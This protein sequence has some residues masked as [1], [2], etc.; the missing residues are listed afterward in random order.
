MMTTFLFRAQNENSGEQDEQKAHSL[1][2]GLRQQMEQMAHLR[3]CERI[4]QKDPADRRPGDVDSL[5]R[6]TKDINFIK[7]LDHGVRRDL[8]YLM[9]A[10]VK[11]VNHQLTLTEKTAAMLVLMRGEVDI[12]TNKPP[13]EVLARWNKEQRKPRVSNARRSSTSKSQSRQSLRSSVHEEAEEQQ[14]AKKRESEK[15]K[16]YEALFNEIDADGNQSLDCDE[17]VYAFTKIGSTISR[18]EVEQMVQDVN[19]DGSW[20]LDFNEFCKV[21]DLQFGGETM[22]W[23]EIRPGVWSKTFSAGEDFGDHLLTGD[24]P[25]NFFCRLFFR[26]ESSCL[27]VYR[28]SYQT[29]LEG[30]FDEKLKHGISLLHSTG[31]FFPVK[32]SPARL[33]SLASHASYSAIEKGALRKKSFFLE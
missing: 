17:L 10:E 15:R 5:N 26:D 19:E 29:V 9:T 32:Q 18:V 31:I 16:A 2:E 28:H 6:Q 21:L 3:R 11:E 20:E 12:T 30:G 14:R 23:E 24:V 33:R 13:N 25:K 22:P 1:L 4:L 27:V 8:C 7:D